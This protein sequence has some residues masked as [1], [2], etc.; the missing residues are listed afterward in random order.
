MRSP[1]FALAFALFL[2][3][4]LAPTSLRADEAHT[5]RDC[6]G[7]PLMTRV[8]AGVFMMGAAPGR[9]AGDE[10]PQHR[11]AVAAFALGVDEVT[12]GQW[13][14][15]AEANPG[16]SES[17]CRTRRGSI[18]SWRRPGFVQDESH[19]VVCVSWEDARDYAAWLTR[20][21]GHRYRL[22]SEAEWEYAARAGARGDYWWGDKARRALANYGATR[23]CG[24]KRGGRWLFTAPA[25]SFPA[26]AF[27]LH[28]TAGNVWEWVEDCYTPSYGAPLPSQCGAHSLRG[29]AYNYGAEEMRITARRRHRDPG[30]GVGFRVARDLRP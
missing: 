20:T 19:P 1:P 18:G 3:V 30:V 26:N 13:A 17:R 11:V 21:T 7:C 16:R 6:A 15:Y 8:P 25:G 12:R 5:F 22:A 14:S 10:H 29:G 24:L 23:C 4:S 28:D 2:F 9:G 27:G